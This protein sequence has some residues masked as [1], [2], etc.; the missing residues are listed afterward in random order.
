M[1]EKEIVDVKG[2]KHNWRYELADQLLAA[3]KANGSW[4]N[5]A[6]PQW[7]EN[8]PH[9]VTGF[10]LIVLAECGKTENGK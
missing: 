8:D 5:E 6:S 4:I 3:Q 2:K 9:L 7:M 1:G 10:V